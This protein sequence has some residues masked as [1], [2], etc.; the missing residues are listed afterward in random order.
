MMNANTRIAVITIIG[1]FMLSM[2]PLPDWAQD[3]RP[4]WVTLV[5]I[6][7]TMALPA[8]IGVTIAWCAGLMLDVSHGALLGQHALG[9][10][11]VIY[12][13]HVQHQR[14]RV[15]SLVQQ[16]I[17]IL[18]LLLMKQA[19]VLWV[20]GIMGHAPDSWLYFMPSLSSALLWPWVYIILRDL[21]RKFALKTHY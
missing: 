12:I 9:L 8:S 18:F 11:L 20:S 19:I 13:I 10:M 4:D 15:A 21:R 5:L 16:A 2:M 7:W 1:A 14:L 17:L 6:Y 3:F